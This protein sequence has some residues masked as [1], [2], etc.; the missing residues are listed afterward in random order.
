[1]TPSSPRTSKTAMNK[2]GRQAMSHWEKTDPERYQAIPDKQA[3]FTEL[4]EQAE[5]EI[6]LRADALAGPDRPGEG[7]LQKVGRLNMARFVAE[8]QVLRELILIEPARQ[9]NEESE[10]GPPDLSTDVMR[11]IHEALQEE[12][13][14]EQG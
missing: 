2:Y 12:D 10:E 9:E 6:D 14:T 8:E 7:T 11:A 1:M 4:G 3:F 13:E 5:Q